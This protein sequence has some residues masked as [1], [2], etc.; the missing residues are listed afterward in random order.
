MQVST[1]L[2]RSHVV[3]GRTALILPTLGR[4]ER[5]RTGGKEQRVTV[6]DSMSAVHASKGP[7]PP[8]SSYLRSEVDIVCSIAEAT[9]PG[10]VPWA[11]FRRDYT[12][13][14][15]AI[16]RVVPG[17]EAYAEKVDRPGG[18]V[19]PHPPRDSRSF[20]TAQ[21]AAIFTV[22]PIDLL[23]V[24]EERL[25]MQTLREQQP[26]LEG[27]HRAPPAGVAG[28]GARPQRRRRRQHGGVHVRR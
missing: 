28:R 26:D 4:S 3:C 9:A 2:N 13:I 11:E 16:S 25:L 8:A 20:P 5:D 18:F 22:S 24:P 6:E 14:R 15:R 17:C 1:K 23:H 10:R 12:S 7:L 19:L 21:N 27:G